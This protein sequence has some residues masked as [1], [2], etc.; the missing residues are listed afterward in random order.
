MTAQHRLAA[1]KKAQGK[2]E[3][4]FP[5]KGRRVFE[6]LRDTWVGPDR[7]AVKLIARAGNEC[8]DQGGMEKF[9]CNRVLGAPPGSRT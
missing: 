6:P 2:A 3:A 8:A 1:F 4:R 9:T 7:D 5:L